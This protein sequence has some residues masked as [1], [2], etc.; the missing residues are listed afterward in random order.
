MPREIDDKK[1][2][3]A[4]RK[5]RKAKERAAREGAELSDWETEFLNGVEERLETYGSAF[6]DPEKGAPDEALSAR[7]AMVIR[8]IDKKS[9]KPGA[10]MKRSSFG[11]GKKKPAF[12]ARSRDIHSDIECVQPPSD[13]APAPGT[14]SAP[15]P[16]TLSPV[17]RR[18]RMSAISPS[19]TANEG[20]A[21]TH[22]AQ[23][24]APR[25]KRKRP[26]LRIIT[27]G[28]ADTQD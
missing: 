23:A 17:E 11:K 5:L 12:K 15:S 4:L 6:N 13:A 22:T 24:N 7:Q 27:G 2:R 8:E 9:R 19:K 26:A 18:A 16:S 21:N 1:T 14:A 3:K 25:V 20:D 10:D 28:K